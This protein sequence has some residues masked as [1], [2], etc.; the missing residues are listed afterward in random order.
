MISNHNNIQFIHNNVNI[1]KDKEIDELVKS[2]RKEIIQEGTP[3]IIDVTKTT[4]NLTIN[5]IKDIIIKNLL[6]DFDAS[7]NDSSAFN[8]SDYENNMNEENKNTTYKNCFRLDNRLKNEK[9]LKDQILFL[10]HLLA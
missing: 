8:G 3:F 9:L 7:D 5:Q 6:P 2:T 1:L 4:N 10:K